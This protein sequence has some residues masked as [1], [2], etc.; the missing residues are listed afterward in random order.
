MGNSDIA[1]NK[2][3]EGYNCA[4]SV[5]FAFMDKLPVNSDTGMK[6]SNGFGGGMGRK[7]EVCG[8]ISG[9]VLVI[10]FL[11]GRGDNDGR[12]KQEHA[13]AAVRE[14]M[15]KFQAAHGSVNC[16]SLLDG[17]ELLTHEGQA[18]FKSEKLSE[19]CCQY[20]DSAVKILE[21]LIEKNDLY[22]IENKT[23]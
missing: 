15:D 21:M 11:Y 10:G 7:Q 18:R 22:N 23:D 6:L 17:C 9:G 2:F 16:R 1:V 4:Q 12:Q 20:V 14:L 8:A 3:K 19:K 13:Y 5:L